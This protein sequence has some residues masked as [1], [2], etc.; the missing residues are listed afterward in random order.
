MHVITVTAVNGL[1]YANV[2]SIPHARFHVPVRNLSVAR[3]T[4]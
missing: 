1:M 3:V 4:I 2:P